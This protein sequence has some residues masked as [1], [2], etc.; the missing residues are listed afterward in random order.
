MAIKIARPTT[1]SAAAT[2]ITKKATTCPLRFPCIRAK[3]TNA[4]LQA[5]SISSTHMKMTMALRRTSTPVAP[6]ANKTTDKKM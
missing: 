2:T 6:I 1:T 3:A 4:R 5:L